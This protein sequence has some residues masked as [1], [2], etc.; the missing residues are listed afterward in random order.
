MGAGRKEENKGDEK[1]AKR[2]AKRRRTEENVLSEGDERCHPAAHCGAPGAVMSPPGL[3]CGLTNHRFDC[4][5]HF[6]WRKCLI[7]AIPSYKSTVRIWFPNWAVLLLGLKCPGNQ[8]SRVQVFREFP[9]PYFWAG[10]VPQIPIDF[11]GSE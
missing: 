4:V 8:S 1:D 6:V 10:K 7:M 9:E 2:D 3:H 5:V 11:S